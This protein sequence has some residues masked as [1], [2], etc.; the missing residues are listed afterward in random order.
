MKA[1]HRSLISMID[2]LDVYSNTVFNLDSRNSNGLQEKALISDT[3][4][5]VD[6]T[7]SPSLLFLVQYYDLERTLYGG[8]RFQDDGS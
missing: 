4:T 3:T 8:R 2:G 5:L 1:N 7:V 6:L